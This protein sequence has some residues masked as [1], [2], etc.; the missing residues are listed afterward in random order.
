MI[1]LQPTRCN[2]CG[3]KVIFTSNA[4]IY[5]RPYGSGKCYLCLECG[6]YVGTHK[7]RPRQAL[8]ILADK[9]MRDAKI[10]CHTL[11]DRLWKGQRYATRRRKY[12]YERLADKL[13]IPVN[14]C[15]F[16]YFDLPMLRRSYVA[17]SEII[18]EDKHA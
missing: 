16:G 13:G 14:E 18:Q 15:H 3:G 2:I 11:F 17:V 6:A 4:E 9:K 12:Y 10:I 7:P 5:G 8:G 1:D